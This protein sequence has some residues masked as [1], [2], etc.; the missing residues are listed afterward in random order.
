[1]TEAQICRLTRAIPLAHYDVG[2]LQGRGRVHPA[3]GSLGPW[4]RLVS[5]AEAYSRPVREVRQARRTV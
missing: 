1:M 5:V 3:F 4:L 2:T